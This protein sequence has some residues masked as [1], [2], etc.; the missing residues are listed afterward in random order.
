MKRK[1]SRAAFQSYLEGLHEANLFCHEDQCPITQFF[2]DV[3]K[4]EMDT[5]DVAM[6]DID[7]I[8]ALDNSSPETMKGQGWGHISAGHALKVLKGV[9]LVEATR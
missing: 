1:Y 7:Y 3:L 2:R 5:G 8:T 6:V 4:Y 9:Q